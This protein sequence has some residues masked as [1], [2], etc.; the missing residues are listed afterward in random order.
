M[1]AGNKFFGGIMNKGFWEDAEVIDL[2]SEVEKVKRE[3]GHLKQAFF[4]HAKKYTRKPNSVRNYYYA[5]VDNLLRNRLRARKL[6]IDLRFHKKQA[7]EFFTN[8]EKEDVISKIKQLVKDGNSVRQ[9]CLKLSGGNI[10]LMLRYQ[11]KYRNEVLKEKKDNK[12]VNILEFKSKQQSLSQTDINSLFLGLVKLVRKTALEEA[13]QEIFKEKEALTTSLN[14]AINEAR[15]KEQ[16]LFL[17][18]EQ[19]EHLKEENKRLQQIVDLKKANRA[20]LLSE[21][22]SK[23]KAGSKEIAK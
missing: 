17:C 23:Y 6:N 14:K 10:A 3:K 4:T 19:L 9:A 12:T 18:Q 2:F 7:V 15:K 8:R 5:E 22:L 16:Q 20:K 13:S 1:Q 21:K 11:N